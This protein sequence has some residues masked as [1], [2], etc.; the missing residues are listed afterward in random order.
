[1]EKKPVPIEKPIKIAIVGPESTG[2]STLSAMLATHYNTCWVREYARDYIDQLGRPYKETDLDEIARGQI[3]LEDRMESSANR[4][5][6]CDTNLIVIKI[7]SEYKYGRCS[8]WIL[9]EISRRRY[10]LHLLTYIDI[11]WEDDPQ[12]EHPHK[13]AYFY[14]RYKQELEYWRF[15]HLE[16]RGNMK[17]RMHSSVAEINAILSAINPL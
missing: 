13:R 5:L 12:R 11:P 10:D 2:K 16:I 8:E 1:M 14:D 9:N 15:R 7:W 4:I 17:K 6:F 3:L